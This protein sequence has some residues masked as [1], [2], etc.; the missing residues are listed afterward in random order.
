ML[1]Q[2]LGQL[3]SGQHGSANAAGMPLGQLS[4]GQVGAQLCSSSGWASQMERLLQG[5]LDTSGTEGC[6]PEWTNNS[7]CALTGGLHECW[8]RSLSLDMSAWRLKK[9]LSSVGSKTAP[10]GARWW[11]RVSAGGQGLWGYS[12]SP[13]A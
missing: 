10:A 6:G 1:E 3:L 5:L 9:L 8:G 13:C 11:G 2:T 4:P 12:P 7:C